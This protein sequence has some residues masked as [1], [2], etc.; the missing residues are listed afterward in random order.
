[1]N[2]EQEKFCRLSDLLLT[3]SLNNDEVRA[4]DKFRPLR[5]TCVTAQG[6][7]IAWR[8]L[9]DTWGQWKQ[10]LQGGLLLPYIVKAPQHFVSVSKAKEIESFYKN[11]DTPAS[12]TRAAKQ[13]V[14]S[15]LKYAHWQQRDI[16]VIGTWCARK[17]KS[18][19]S[20]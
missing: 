3:W 18:C 9:Q 15:V 2:R 8:F 19:T 5:T 7:D 6:R 4:Q 14:E 10:M 1:M 11:N 20:S 17:A 16:E 12:C 13:C